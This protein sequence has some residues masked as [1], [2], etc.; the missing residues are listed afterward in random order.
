ML[1]P[2]QKSVQVDPDGQAPCMDEIENQKYRGNRFVG[3][4][5]NKK[6]RRPKSWPGKKIPA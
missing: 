4:W 5:F 2:N 1:Q 3:V 6:M